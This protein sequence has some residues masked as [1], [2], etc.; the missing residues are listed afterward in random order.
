M[1]SEIDFQDLHQLLA[2]GDLRNQGCQGMWICSDMSNHVHEPYTFKTQFIRIA[3]NNGRHEA[4]HFG[5]F[6]K[7]THFLVYFFWV[8]TCAGV[9]KITNIRSNK[10]ERPLLVAAPV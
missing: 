5:K 1:N 9:Q 6:S 8:L 4:G 7:I 10:R 3:P 2:F